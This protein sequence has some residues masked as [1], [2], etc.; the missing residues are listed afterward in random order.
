MPRKCVQNLFRKR[1]R[2]PRERVREEVVIAVFESFDWHCAY[3]GKKPNILTVDHVVP[4]STGGTNDISNLLP[5]C[6]RCNGRKGAKSLTNWYNERNPR[7]SSERW[8]RIVEAL[9]FTDQQLSA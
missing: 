9:G 3:C 8:E 2:K 7:Y 5:A 1:K 6:S 4:R